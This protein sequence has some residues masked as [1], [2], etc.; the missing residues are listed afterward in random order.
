[1]EYSFIS[2]EKKESSRSSSFVGESNSATLPVQ[3]Q[4]QLRVSFFSEYYWLCYNEQVSTHSYRRML[5]IRSRGRSLYHHW[6]PGQDHYLW[7]CGFCE[8]W[9]P[10]S[11]FWTL[12]WLFFES[13][14]QWL[15]QPMLLLHPELGCCSFLTRLFQDR[16][17]AFGPHS[18]S[19]H[20][21]PLSK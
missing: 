14:H 12:D 3:A 10:Q 7:P 15:H 9:W 11:G 1:M 5:I 16:T 8:L 4:Y 18:S 21:Q 6:G 17:A 19:L 20:S 13:L 2:F